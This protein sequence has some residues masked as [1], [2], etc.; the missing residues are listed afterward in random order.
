MNVG[1]RVEGETESPGLKKGGVLQLVRAEVE[2]VCRADSIPEE[3]V[4]SMAGKDIGDSV[5][6]SE[7]TLPEGVHPSVQDRD[8]TIASVV[9]TRTS[10][11]ADLEEGA[12]AP[13]EEAE[14][15][16]EAE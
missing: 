13:A 11:M 2:V 4:V 1:V 12:G 16:A 14:G 3:L 6:M 7:I 15:E 5:H 10:T 8:F 9:G